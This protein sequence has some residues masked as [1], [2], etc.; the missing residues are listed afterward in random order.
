MEEP[1][2]DTPE[3]SSM[4]ASGLQLLL[5]PT[6]PAD[7]PEPHP[8]ATTAQTAFNLQNVFMGTSPT[9]VPCV[10]SIHCTMCC[11]SSCCVYI[12]V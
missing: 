9:D 1:L 3:M 4:S 5:E 2:L 6:L 12:T 8:G 10:A 11:I 7:R